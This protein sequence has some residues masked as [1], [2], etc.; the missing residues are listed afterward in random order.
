MPIGTDGD[1]TDDNEGPHCRNCHT[2]GSDCFTCHTNDDTYAVGST[3]LRDVSSAYTATIDAKVTNQSNY[4]PITAYRQSAVVGAVGEACLDGGF[5]FP[6]RTLGKDML[7]DELYGVDFDGTPIGPGDVRT[8]NAAT[9]AAGFG[10]A[11]QAGD[12][13]QV[14]VTSGTY[15]YT[16]SRNATSIIAAVRSDNP[17]LVGQPAENMDSVCID[18]HGDATYWNG[19]D[20]SLYVYKPSAITTYGVYGYGDTFGWE[21][22]LKGL[23]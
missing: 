22:L 18:C 8:A 1:G 15:Y 5:S 9:L 2:G 6:H 16:E 3:T 19:D 23:P 10:T 17:A 7:K 12:E 20:A 21:L 11:Q 4:A 14:Y 13:F